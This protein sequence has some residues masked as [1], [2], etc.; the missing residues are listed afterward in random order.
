MSETLRTHPSVAKFTRSDGKDVYLNAHA[1]AVVVETT[2]KEQ[3]AAAFSIVWLVSGQYIWLQES[4]EQVAQKL[5]WRAH[6]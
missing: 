2:E 1:V 3:K 5:D 6:R 4:P